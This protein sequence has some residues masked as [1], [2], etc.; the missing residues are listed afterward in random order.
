[1]MKNACSGALSAQF[2][3]MF[4]FSKV[5]FSSSF[6]RFEYS[7]TVAKQKGQIRKVFYNVR[8]FKTVNSDIYILIW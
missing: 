5:H 7:Q 2:K 3:N 1:M 6:S 4:L 8:L